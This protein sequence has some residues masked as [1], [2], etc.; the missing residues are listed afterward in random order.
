MRISVVP[1]AFAVFATSL[2]GVGLCSAPAAAVAPSNDLLANA[3]LITG[4][5][6][7]VTGTT[8]D[9]TWTVGEPEG[10][11]P[12]NTDPDFTR[13][14]WYRVTTP[15]D[16]GLSF[17]VPVGRSGISVGTYISSDGGALV[18]QID[19]YSASGWAHQVEPGVFETVAAYAGMFVTDTSQDDPASTTTYYVRVATTTADAGPFTLNWSEAGLPT[20]TTA[21]AT[22]D[23]AAGTFRIDPST[24]CTRTFY[25]G[26]P[27]TPMDPVD[28]GYYIV[29]DAN[30]DVVG[31]QRRWEFFD[32]TPPVIPDLPLLPGSH[33]Y[34]VRFYYGSRFVYCAR[35]QAE[36]TVVGKHGTTTRLRAPST[37]KVG[38]RPRVRA[39]VLVGSEAAQGRVVIRVNGNNVATRQLVGGVASVRLPKLKRGETTVAAIYK[40]TATNA[41]SRTSRV[42]TVTRR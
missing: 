30:G 20:S 7:S 26:P 12:E 5:S 15:D 40:A 35:S 33:T 42:I 1:T 34:T 2:V 4:E 9:A 21:T 41:S 3:T 32:S 13:S 39:K 31:S 17:T 23:H 16:V 19:N 38:D 28:S 29:R 37:A 6:G 10:W 11:D 8:T 24:T 36:V 22:P 27:P 25:N 14:V 18:Q